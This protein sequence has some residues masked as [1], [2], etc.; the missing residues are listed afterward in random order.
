MF[1]KQRIKQYVGD[2]GGARALVDRSG[3]IGMTVDLDT[4]CRALTLR[5]LGRS[6]LGLDLAAR[7]EA[8]QSGV[9]ASALIVDRR[10]GAQ[11]GRE[12]ARSGSA[13]H[14]RPAAWAASRSNATLHAASRRK[15][16]RSPRSAGRVTSPT[17]GAAGACVPRPI[18]LPANHVV[19]SDDEICHA[20]RARVRGPP[21]E[22]TATTPRPAHLTGR[23]RSGL[24]ARRHP[25]KSTY[26][27]PPPNVR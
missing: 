27:P 23:T 25:A 24:T 15:S 20:R 10:P 1:T 11:S 6:V 9:A 8:D 13:Y 7:A 14:P 16:I 3:A 17:G 12:S 22:A 2:M 5:A 26:Q 4:E 18:L 21:R 19:V